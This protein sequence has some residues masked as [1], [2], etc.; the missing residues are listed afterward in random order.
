MTKKKE[1]GIF[2]ICHQRLEGAPD[3]P[4]VVEAPLTQANHWLTCYGPAHKGAC[5]TQYF[6]TAK[7]A[8][9]YLNKLS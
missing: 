5:S 8:T 7:K 9:A 6:S 1:Q 3:P 4:F 2:I